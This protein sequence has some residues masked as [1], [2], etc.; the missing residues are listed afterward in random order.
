ME[1]RDLLKLTGL[2]LM[3]LAAPEAAPAQ[4]LPGDAATTFMHVWADEGGVTHV[5]LR[6]I[7]K[8]AKPLPFGGQMNLHFDS[9]PLIAQH[10]APRRQFVVTL[11]GEFEIEGSDG[12]RMKPPASGLSY[13]DDTVG[14]GHIARLSNA[15]NINITAPDDFDVLR[16]ARGEG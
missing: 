9:R 3:G 10:K 5:T 15:V 14:Q 16:W 13:F 7:S 4:D 8:A 12:T 1:R 11:Q 6:P 2:A